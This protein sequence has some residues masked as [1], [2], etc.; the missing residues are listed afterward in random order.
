MC[1][2]YAVLNEVVDVIALPAFDPVVYQRMKKADEIV[3]SQN[4]IDQVRLFVVCI[5]GMY[6]SNPFHNFDHASHV[7][8]SVSKLLARIVGAEEILD[9]DEN[10]AESEHFGW[11]IHDHTYGITSDPMTQFS[12]VLAAL[13]HD[14]DHLGVSNAQ[15]VKEG[16]ELADRFKNKSV[17]EQN[18]T[19]LAWELLMD[20]RF[21]DFRRTIYADEFGLISLHRA[22]RFQRHSAII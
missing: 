8:M 4:V 15:L 2:E 21:E 5:A 12:V 14:L 1:Q 17:A 11:S 19:V 22:M 9:G 7:M 18:S 6:H 20:P 16:H 10:A 13:V 3:L